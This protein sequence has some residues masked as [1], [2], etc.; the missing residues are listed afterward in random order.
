MAVPVYRPGDLLQLIGLD[1][2]ALLSLCMCSGR[3]GRVIF[4]NGPLIHSSVRGSHIVIVYIIIIIL[5]LQPTV[6]RG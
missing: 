1:P 5:H 3:R 4:R 6:K 2:A